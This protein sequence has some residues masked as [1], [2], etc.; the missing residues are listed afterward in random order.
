FDFYEVWA[1]ERTVA[2][3]LEGAA[4]VSGDRLMLRRALGN[5]LSNA[6]RHTPAGGTV[7]VEL[8]AANDGEIRI[9]VENPCPEIP[10][11][12]LPKLFERFYRVDPSRQRGG[13]GAGLGLAIVKSIVTAHGGNIDA[14]STEG[15][16]RFTITLP[17]SPG[18]VL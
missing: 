7:R 13:D 6:I 4:T 18:P 14:T 15:S 1:E 17:G 11:E 9:E 12:H 2:L 10:P 16:T 8:H 3:A 5:L